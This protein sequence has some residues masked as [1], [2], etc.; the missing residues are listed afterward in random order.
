[1]PEF[2]H[3]C[4]EK[5]YN[6]CICFQADPIS[7]PVNASGV[8]QIRETISFKGLKTYIYTLGQEGAD[9]HRIAQLKPSACA[10]K[11]GSVHAYCG[12]H[13]YVNDRMSTKKSGC[14]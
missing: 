6:L 14:M 1:M 7:D 5:M 3:T 12:W 2:I 13:M 9:K 4:I 10:F 8:L 11:N